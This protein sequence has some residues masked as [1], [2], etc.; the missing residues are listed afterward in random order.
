MLGSTRHLM[1]AA[2]L[3]AASLA[4]REAVGPADRN[5]PAVS[6]RTDV[7]GATSPAIDTT[8]DT[9]AGR[10][11]T[12]QSTAADRKSVSITVYNQNF[13]LVREVRD[14]RFTRGIA[15]LEY[16]DVAQHVQP[17]TVHI[18]PLD[19]GLRVLEQNYQFDL[20]NPQKLLEKYV[21]RTVTVYRTNPQTGVD[22]PVTAEVLSVNGGPILKI[23]DEVTFGYPGRFSF[24]EIPDN[25]IAKPTLVWLL[26]SQRARQDL[27]VSY[28]TNNM[29]WKADYVFVV[30]EKDEHGDLTGWV[31][32][33]NQSGTTYENA[34]LKLVA[35][36]VQRL[37]DNLAGRMKDEVMRGMVAEAAAPQ[38]SEESFFEYHLYTLDRPTTLR[39]NE[40]KQVTLLE[41]SEV[42]V[43][44]KLVFYGAAQ[45][46]RSQYG[47]VVSNQKLSVYL[48]FQNSVKNGLGMPLPKGVVRVYKADGSGAQQFIGEDRI[49][50]TPRDERV[51]I[52]MGEAF[53]VVGD[54]RQVEF[55]ILSSC[56]TESQW[57]VS[58]RNHKKERA[59]I[60]VI[61][62]V[63]GDWE[64]LSSTHTYR[65]LDAHT[66]AYTVDVAAD[67]EVKIV[68]RV[69]V[70]WC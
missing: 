29:N 10:D 14:V 43:E 27:E 18:R 11:A 57:E 22:E 66:F 55:K 36:D 44:K 62:P 5:G 35:G 8:R 40:Q 30:D 63:G 9:R 13:G 59:R 37:T 64:I 32:L 56:V 46:Y 48:D 53:D 70:R 24:P 28:L 15:S 2:L 31:T 21:G 1:V 4:G 54:R 34:Q 49:D 69:R 25:L 68:Y 38:F 17:E 3:G 58:L 16:R 12:Y 23:G 45:Y 33:T 47:E 67:G 6:P 39:E 42:G 7:H 19:G 52:R 60:D 20:L 26:D 65:K 41:A 61:E 50:H 51:R